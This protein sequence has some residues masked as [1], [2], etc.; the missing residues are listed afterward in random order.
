MSTK[1]VLFAAE[2]E[3]EAYVYESWCHNHCPDVEAT[4]WGINGDT[5]EL[6]RD[7]NNNWV[8]P[9]L[10]PPWEWGAEVFEEPEGGEAM[11]V[12][13]VLVN[14]VTWPPDPE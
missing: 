12:A 11:R 10:G 5:N 3:V 8:V 7:I 6:N 9:Y 2:D 1:F 4:S 13:G 14:S